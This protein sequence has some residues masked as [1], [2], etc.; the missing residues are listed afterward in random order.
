MGSMVISETIRRNYKGLQRYS[1]DR[2]KVGHMYREERERERGLPFGA[3]FFSRKSDINKSKIR[4]VQTGATV[5]MIHQFLLCIGNTGSKAI[6]GLK[7]DKPGAKGLPK[8]PQ[9]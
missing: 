5:F 4:I 8:P 1:D 3:V 9:P 2:V 7:I 6:A